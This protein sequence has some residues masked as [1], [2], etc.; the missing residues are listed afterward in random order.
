MKSFSC[1]PA[2]P[3]PEASQFTRINA[4]WDSAFPVREIESATP[5]TFDFGAILPFTGVPAYNFPVYASQWPSPDTTQD[6][7]RGC[8]LGFTAVTISGN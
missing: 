2:V 5:I 4:S 6:S 8:L 7:V 1:M 3:T